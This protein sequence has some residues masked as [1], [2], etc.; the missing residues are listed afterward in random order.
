MCPSTS[1]TYDILS[2]KGDSAFV[3]FMNSKRTCKR[4]LKSFSLKSL[5]I[6][7]Y[8]IK[9][10]T[11]KKMATSNSGTV[12][13]AVYVTLER[14]VDRNILSFI[15]QDEYHLKKLAVGAY[16]LNILHTQLLNNLIEYDCKVIS[17]G[18]FVICHNYSEHNN[19]LNVI[20]FNTKPTILKKESCIF[21]IIYP[22]TR[23]SSTTTT[24]TTTNGHGNNNKMMQGHRNTFSQ[25]SSKSD[26]DSVTL[27]NVPIANGNEHGDESSLNVSTHAVALDERTTSD[28]STSRPSSRTNVRGTTRESSGSPASEGITRTDSVQQSKHHQLFVDTFR[29]NDDDDD[30]SGSDA[31]DPGS[32]QSVRRETDS[33]IEYDADA[34]DNDMETD[35]VDDE[36]VPP[37]KRQKFNDA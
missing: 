17:C 26:N 7:K 13:I 1:D 24:T 9:N 4:L 14:K 10:N 34:N 2:G 15:V 36:L 18:D 37:I 20:L 30:D 27:I 3:R 5:Y 25:R 22:T 35:D 31:G 16:S 33:D 28:R 32:K 8:I 21:K 11:L 19:G 29:N 6:I 23:L 12:N